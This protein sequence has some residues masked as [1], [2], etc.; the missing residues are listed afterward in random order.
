MKD[1]EI[2]EGKGKGDKPVTTYRV[3]YTRKDRWDKFQSIGIGALSSG[4]LIALLGYFGTGYFNK[5]QARETDFRLYSEIMNQRE[6]ADNTL[7]SEMFQKIFDSFLPTSDSTRDQLEPIE[8]INNDIFSL[9]LLTRNFHE[10]IDIKPLF[11]FIL[12]KIIQEKRESRRNWKKIKM[13]LSAKLGDKRKTKNSLQ[14]V[15]K[16]SDDILRFDR[17][18]RKKMLDDLIKIKDDNSLPDLKREVD[19][20]IMLLKDY[21]GIVSSYKK[22]FKVAE[23]IR[24]KQ[25][26]V[27]REMGQ[28][29]TIKVP[30]RDVCTD[31]SPRDTMKFCEG[32]WPIIKKKTLKI[33]D[34]SNGS[35]FEREFT[36]TISRAYPKWKQVRVRVEAKKVIIRSGYSKREMLQEK[37]S[38]TD[39]FGSAVRNVPENTMGEIRT[40]F[41]E[42]GLDETPESD[43]NH[44]VT[45]KVL[46][47]V[48]DTK[49][50]MMRDGK[51]DIFGFAVRQVPGFDNMKEIRTWFTELGL[52]ETLNSDLEYSV[53]FMK[54]DETKNEMKKKGKTNI[55]ESADHYV[56]ENKIEAMRTRF[57][58]SE[59]NE[60]LESDIKY[61]VVLMKKGDTKR[62]MMRD[63]KTDIFGSAVRP[64]PEFKDIKIRTWFAEL[65]LDD[66][67]DSDVIDPVT[68]EI[69]MEHG[70]SKREMMKDGKT[71]IFGNGYSKWMDIK[72]IDTNGAGNDDQEFWV[73]AF[74][75]PLVDSTYLSREE[76]FSVV[77]E[78][79][80]KDNAKLILVYF[81][82]KYTGLKEKSFYH[83]RVLNHLENS[84]I[85]KE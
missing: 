43:V 79:I 49:R 63:G 7:R 61:S 64:V 59:P 35:S 31:L 4:I 28:H 32:M 66:T 34:A 19:D 23:R 38:I 1:N 33:G 67:P 22:L 84:E 85:F 54:K 16:L 74:D 80:D 76:R 81:P 53:V 25:V 44:P 5:K 8:K 60:R 40:W 75:F 68:K 47:R 83:Q 45:D 42:L 13:T 71:D 46:M 37:G 15:F 58:N 9:E 62:K 11:R 27:L 48:G 73:E 3:D 10:S 78:E 72:D 52:D 20:L 57:E 14:N 50:E 70:D 21:R 55:F 18:K 26:E 69:L 65:G 36:V 12:F 82:S 41:A 51:T 77:I 17:A 2:A 6:Q 39:I 24:R 30:T 56:P 29:F